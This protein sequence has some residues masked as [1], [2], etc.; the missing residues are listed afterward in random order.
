MVGVDR[1]GQ[2]VHLCLACQGRLEP[3]RRGARLHLVQGSGRLTERKGKQPL[4]RQGI[5]GLIE[6]PGA[7]HDHLPRVLHQSQAV[8]RYFRNAYFL[9]DGGQGLLHSQ[10][11]NFFVS[12]LLDGPQRE[13]IAEA[14][15]A[16]APARPW[17][18]QMQALP[19]AKVLNVGTDDPAGFFAR[20][21][22]G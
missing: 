5:E 19:I 16:F 18:H 12:E 15:E 20:I 13:Q 11:R 9:P 17:M 22:I 7:E 2:L 3:L 14:V 4:A 1:L 6:H 21:S 10:R 8:E